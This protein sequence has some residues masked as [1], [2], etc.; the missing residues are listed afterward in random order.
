[1]SS[2][3]DYQ[4]FTSPDS[5]QGQQSL[6]TQPQLQ[7]PQQPYWQPSPP[8]F[9]QKNGLAITALVVASLALLMGLGGFVSQIFMGA[10]FSGPMP[11]GG[12][13]QGT[14]PQVVAGQTY[15][16]TLMQHE[17]SRVIRGDGGDVASISCPATPAVV[18][19]A[20]TVCHGVVDG[21]DTSVKVTFEDSVGH[22][23][24]VES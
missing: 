24:L 5:W 18:T 2:P 14:A 10:I 11:F 12:D 4:P 8:V 13:M 22:F 17:V 6:A 15:P 20:V 1:M 23:T 16:G 9:K 7:E 3:Y 21:S 19:D